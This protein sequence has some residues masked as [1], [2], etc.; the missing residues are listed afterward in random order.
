MQPGS[1]QP[2][3]HGGV[4]VVFRDNKLRIWQNAFGHADEVYVL[5]PWPDVRAWVRR[6]GGPWRGAFCPVW[7]LGGTFSLREFDE[8]IPPE[9]QA[10][11]TQVPGQH[12]ALLSLLARVPEA[13]DLARHDLA[14]TWLVANAK[15]I[16]PRCGLREVRRAL[17]RGRWRLLQLLDVPAENCVLKALRRLD[18]TSLVHVSELAALQTL[19]ADD[20]RE[21]RH[22]PRID[23]DI[24]AL[25]GAPELR[26]LRGPG[27]LRELALRP[28]SYWA[29]GPDSATAVL[30]RVLPAS[31]LA[32]H[33]VRPARSLAELERADQSARRVLDSISR[34]CPTWLPA[35]S[36]PPPP[37]QLGA[38]R[39]VNE[40]ELVEEGATMQ[41]CIA[42]PSGKYVAE[43]RA[44]RAA[45][46]HLSRPVPAT[47]YLVH[48]GKRWHFGE[49]NGV[50]NARVPVRLEELVRGWVGHS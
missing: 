7:Q 9:I 49:V 21:L 27:L 39:L 14:L 2:P 44:G 36:L 13:R 31:L 8:L 12:F 43:L 45:V 17:A 46:F 29:S 26:H 24:L 16:A 11:L 32:G 34:H 15:L 18:L 35:P 40:Y 33:T 48:S 6:A 5:R 23:G 1:Y 37:P 41:H 22:V 19:T 25:L 47:L 42:N 28:R 38:T 50:R 30:W 20:L 10:V 3:N 4:N